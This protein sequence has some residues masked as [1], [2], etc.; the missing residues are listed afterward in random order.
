MT[1]L[2]GAILWI[3]GAAVWTA[4]PIVLGVIWLSSE[5]CRGMFGDI[6]AMDEIESGD[7]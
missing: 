5:M 2:I 6:P 4:C 3:T 7:A 1:N